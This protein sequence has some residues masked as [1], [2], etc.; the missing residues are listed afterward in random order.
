[1][2]SPAGEWMESFE[3]MLRRWVVTVWTD[4]HRW[5]AISLLAMPRATHVNMSRSRSLSR[6]SCGS[7]SGM[8]VE[9][10]SLPESS[11]CRRRASSMC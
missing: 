2:V 10:S 5:S 11:I 9:A 7:S 3:Q 1:M 4:R 6:A 8:A